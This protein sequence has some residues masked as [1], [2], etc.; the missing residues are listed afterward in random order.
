MNKRVYRL[1]FDDQN[2]STKCVLCEQLGLVA[3]F[4]RS[5]EDMQRSVAKLA[6]DLIGEVMIPCFARNHPQ[7]DDIT[8]EVLNKNKK[9][10]L[11]TH[12]KNS[13][14][15][16][17]VTDDIN[18][19][20]KLKKR[21]VLALLSK[22]QMNFNATANIIKSYEGNVFFHAP[23][24]TH[25]RENK[26]SIKKVYRFIKKMKDE[27]YVVRPYPGLGVA[28][29][30]API[31]LDFEPIAPIL[32]NKNTNK[33]ITYSI[34]I[35]VFEQKKY[36]LRVLECIERQQFNLEELEVIV[37]DDGGADLLK[38]DLEKRNS[39]VSIKYHY[40]QREVHRVMGDFRFRAGIARN[41]GAKMAVGKYFFFLDADVLLPENALSLM[42][43]EVKDTT[44]L[45]IK[46]FDLK[47]SATENFNDI[48]SIDKD[49]DIIYEEREYWYDFFKKGKDWNTMKDSW[50][51]ICTYGLCMRSEDF[52]NYGG[53]QNNYVG[54]GFEDTDLG[55]RVFQ[56]NGSFRLSNVDSY[57]QYHSHERSEF[58]N[59]HISRRRLLSRTAKVFFLNNLA[60]EIYEGLG[61]YM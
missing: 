13:S 44:L 11:I 17:F 38:H 19:C 8:L 15:G 45:Q 6:N 2:E 26:L 59:S 32:N 14:E 33:E 58:K 16:L 55:F 50:K 42:L 36:L 54:Y 43:K 7:Y 22:R 9:I 10:S 52:K 48:A 56:N 35:P 1:Q 12:D 37:I 28:E 49:K 5:F 30:R 3:P 27:D 60:I 61:D 20:I 31:D 39:T 29:T 57:H 51:Y 41:L 4:S 47:K 34:I 25:F 21:D 40:L 24:K 18:D 46:R 23:L 53:F